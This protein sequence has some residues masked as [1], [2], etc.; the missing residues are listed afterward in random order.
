[1]LSVIKTVITFYAD[2]SQ[3]Y[4]SFKGNQQLV[5]SRQ[6]LEQCLTDISSWMLANGLKINHDKTKLMCIYS[7]SLSRPPLD[8][9]VV[10]G[11][12][13]VPCISA[14]NLE[15]VFDECMTGELQVS[16]TC[17]SSYFHLRNLSSIRIY[18][19]TNAAHTIVH[20]LISSRLDYCNALL[21]GLPKYLVDRLQ[22]VQNSAARV[23]TFTGKFDH[24]PPV[25]IDLYWLPV[26]YR[27]I[28]KLLFSLYKALNGMAPCYLLS[29]R[30]SCYSLCSV[31]NELLVE[32]IAK[33]T[34][35][36]FRS[37]S[38]PAPRLWNRL[39]S[40]VRS[41][42]SVASFKSRLAQNVSLY[43]IS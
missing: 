24:I 9:I 6:S 17:K 28:F 38:F 31:T 15:V 19:T 23:V 14:V 10:C 30:S 29:Y 37:F 35:Y 22:H 34:T 11:E 12:T 32:P 13:I 36:G 4:F 26:Y 20:A 18:L 40:D 41:C 16:K 21:Y 39:P 5:Q 8:E 25:L 33:L 2:N 1:M 42:S 43:I 27:L 7:R 3:L